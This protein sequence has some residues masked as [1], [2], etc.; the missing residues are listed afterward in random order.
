MIKFLDYKAVNSPYFDEIEA[1]MSRVL[2]SG[3]YVL[4]EEVDQFEQEYAQYCG[5]K[6]C[7]GV[8]SGLDALILIFRAWK[9]LGLINEGDEVIVP[10]NTYIASVLA[11]T[12]NRLTPILVEPHEPTYNLDP[13]KIEAAIT[14][15]TK[16]ILAVH[17]YGQCADMEAINIIAQKHGLLVAEDAAQSH[18]A[19]YK[20]RKSGS[21]SDAAAHSFYPGKNLGAIGEGGAVTTDNEELA[22]LIKITRNYGSHIKYQ[23]LV[24][25]INSR[26]DELQASILR[27]KL[28]HLDADNLKRQSIAEVYQNN[29]NNPL[30]TLPTILEGNTS[31]WHLFVVRVPERTRFQELLKEH[32]IDCAIHYP[33]PPHLQPA[34]R[35]WNSKSY[36]ITEAMHKEVISLPMSPALTHQEA[37]QVCEV[38]GKFQ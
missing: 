24:Q 6:F 25:G 5:T 8:G 27:V 35:E 7:I 15:K 33:T 26:L 16:A 38:A 17:L 21:L 18:G 1:A 31:C 22:N 14:S 11:I 4:G 10:A 28:K 29:I 2:R 19:L 30:I 37:L 23:N 9:Q 20:G 12:E 32:N 3:W 36:P 34:Y 13:E